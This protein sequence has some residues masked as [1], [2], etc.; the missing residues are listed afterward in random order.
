MILGHHVDR[1]WYIGVVKLIEQARVL[2]D[3]READEKS[4]R[5]RP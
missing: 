2:K 3:G 5:P 1:S 4:G